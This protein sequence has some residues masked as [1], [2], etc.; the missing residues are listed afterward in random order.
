MNC[1]LTDLLTLFLVQFWGERA[2]HDFKFDDCYWTKQI[3]LDLSAVFATGEIED[4]GGNAALPKLKNTSYLELGVDLN[5]PISEY[6]TIIL[7]VY[8][9]ELTETTVKDE[10][11]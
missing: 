4:K 6:F 5:I 3:G 9:M 10:L 1:T 8:I 11:A 7:R 2:N